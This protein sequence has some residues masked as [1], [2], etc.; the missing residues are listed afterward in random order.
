MYSAVHQ[1]M[2]TRPAGRRLVE[3]RRVHVCT[4]GRCAG[5]VGPGETPAG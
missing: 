2:H 4:A 3:W 1:E 5:R